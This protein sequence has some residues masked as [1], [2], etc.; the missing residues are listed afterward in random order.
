MNVIDTIPVR[1]REKILWR[2]LLPIQN[3]LSVEQ[4]ESWCK[5]VGYVWRDR[6][7]GPMVTLLACIKKELEPGVSARQIE[8]WVAS[9]D[10]GN[11]ENLRDGHDFCDA[12]KRLPLAIFE[13][14]LHCVGNIAAAKARLSFGLSVRNLDGTGL[15]APRTEENCSAFGHSSSNLGKSVLP[16]VRLLCLICAATGAVIRVAMG[17]WKESE[18]RLLLGMLGSFPKNI[19]VVGDTAFGS[20]LALEKLRAQDCH[21]LFRNHRTRRKECIERLGRGDELHLLH[22]PCPCDSA[23]PDL[24]RQTPRQQ[25]VRI[26]RRMI[27][28]KGYKSY[29]LEICTTLLDPKIYLADELIL[30]YLDRWTIEGDFRSIK[31]AFDIDRLTAKTPDVIKKEIYSGLLAYNVVQTMMSLSGKDVRT[32]STTRARELL[33]DACDTMREASTIRLPQIYN[34]ILKLIGSAVVPEQERPPEPRLVIIN[35]NRYRKLK[36]SR[37]QWKIKNHVA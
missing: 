23:F 19:L 35:D 34:H 27:H 21:G 11:P 25:I 5:E 31:H 36:E 26:I 22:R 13:R 4:V 20:Y 16:V 14:A 18:M 12:R 7:F 10:I 6:I 15:K 9:F 3:L 24:I 32:L 29:E 1:N 8:D 33:S 37:A 17:S 2:A 30:L 28:R